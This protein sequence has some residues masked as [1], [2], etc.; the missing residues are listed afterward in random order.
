MTKTHIEQTTQQWCDKICGKSRLRPTRNGIGKHPT[1]IFRLRNIQRKCFQIQ[2]PKYWAV[3]LPLLYQRKSLTQHAKNIMPGIITEV[4]Q[5]WLAN[6]P[7]FGVPKYDWNVSKSNNRKK[8][9]KDI[10]PLSFFVH[11]SFAYLHIFITFFSFHCCSSHK[12]F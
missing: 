3:L 4:R 11:F 7:L 12:E 10:F 1:P 6:T 8:T 2:I 9:W 5:I